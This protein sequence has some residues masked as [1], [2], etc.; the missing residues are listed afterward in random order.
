MPQL[1]PADSAAARSEVRVGKIA[2]FMASF[3]NR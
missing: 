2:F 3:P 1:F